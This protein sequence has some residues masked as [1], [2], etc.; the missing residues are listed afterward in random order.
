VAPRA[1]YVMDAAFGQCPAEDD[2]SRLQYQQCN[3]QSCPPLSGSGAVCR[4]NIDLVIILD[5]SSRVGKT[6]FADAKDFVKAIVGSVARPRSGGPV[7]RVAVVLSG[8]P[9]TWDTYRQCLG[10]M[11]G[12]TRDSCGTEVATPLSDDHTATQLAVDGLH[13]PAAPAQYSAGSFAAAQSLL[14]EGGRD[15]AEQVVLVLASGRPL[16]SSR[17]AAAV[18]ELRGIARV[19]WVVVAGSE[20]KH[21]FNSMSLREAASW[22]SQPVHANVLVSQSFADLKAP[23]KVADVVDSLCGGGAA[24]R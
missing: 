7:G 12:G 1:R 11:N 19:A 13:W 10:L 15:D 23:A 21:T 17:T 4:A 22:A 14:S 16:S 5:G 9:S 18:A 24:T 3:K 20:R 2:A 6:G 8:G